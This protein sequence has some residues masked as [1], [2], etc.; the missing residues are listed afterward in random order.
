VACA[1][2]FLLDNP[3]DAFRDGPLD[4]GSIMADYCDN[5]GAARFSEMVD[6]IPNHRMTCY[7]ACQLIER[8]HACGLARCQDDTADTAH[9]CL[10]LWLWDMAAGQG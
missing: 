2:L 10:L 3:L 4:V 1:A 7:I 8:T 5:P 9:Y 6:W